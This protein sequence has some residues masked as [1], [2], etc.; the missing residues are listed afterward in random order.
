[1]NV[2]PGASSFRGAWGCSPVDLYL[3]APLAQ[4]PEVR[5]DSVTLCL[6]GDSIAHCALTRTP[7][8]A[9]STARLTLKVGSEGVRVYHS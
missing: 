4:P 1:M 9:G 3:D 5:R 8:G 2:V 7:R 6:S